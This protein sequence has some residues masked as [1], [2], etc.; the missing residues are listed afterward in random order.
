[1]EKHTS[2]GA[3]GAGG[4]RARTTC[5]LPDFESSQ[6]CTNFHGYVSQVNLG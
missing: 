2:T 5:G 4:G 6:G 1:M 3:R